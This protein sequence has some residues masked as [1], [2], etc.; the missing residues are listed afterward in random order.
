MVRS[1]RRS[2]LSGL[3]LFLLFIAAPVQA[4]GGKGHEIVAYIAAAHLTKTARN[5]I[6]AI[7]PKDETLAQA[8]TLPDR[9]KPDIPELNPLHYVDLPRGATRYDRERDCP[10]RN[11]IVEAIPWYLHVLVAKDAP[12]AE[13]Q[14]ALNYVV[15]LVGDIHQPLHVGF[16]DDLGGTTTMVNFRGIEQQLHILWDSGLLDTE[17][18]SAEEMAKRLDRQVNDDERTVWEMG[19]PADWANES[20]ALAVKY[21]YPLPESHE[22]GEDYA[23]RALPIIHRRL[24]QAGARLAWLLNQAL[25]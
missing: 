8:A 12:L 3:T 19:R 24:T 16:I 25:K 10:Q 15:H 1:I 21:A 20:L 23:N 22:I 11:C 4:W 18:E 7:L 13:K 9:I 2:F 14:I 6:K 5:K 17:P